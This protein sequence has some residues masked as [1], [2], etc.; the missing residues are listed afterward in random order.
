MDGHKLCRKERQRRRGEGIAEY[1]KE[2]FECCFGIRDRLGENSGVGVRE[3]TTEGGT[4]L[5]K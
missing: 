1:V 5:R 4:V 3:E 2:Q